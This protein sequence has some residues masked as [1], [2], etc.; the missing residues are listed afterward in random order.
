M[1]HMTAT[2]GITVYHG[3][4]WFW[5]AAYLHLHV[6]YVETWYSIGTHIATTAFHVHVASRTECLVA[7]SCQNHDTDALTLTAIA[8][9]L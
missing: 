7:C 9:G 8:E 4:D 1:E 3:D 5:Q 6:E 2:D